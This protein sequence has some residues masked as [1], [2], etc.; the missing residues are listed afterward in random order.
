MERETLQLFLA[1]RDTGNITRAASERYITQSA[2]SKRIAQLEKE[3]GVT[4]F[5]RGKGHSTVALTPAGE[6]FSDIAERMLLLY[7][8]ALALRENAGQRGLTVACINS[9]QG[10]TL[11]GFIRELQAQH[12]DLCVTLEDHHSVEIF[13]LLENKRLDLGITQL[14][15]P[16]SDLVSYPL[17][18]EGYRVVTLPGADGT[19]AEA[20]VHPAHLPAE[21]EIFEAFDTEFQKWHDYWWRPSGCKIRVNTTPTAERYFCDPEDWMI[22]PETVAYAMEQKG[23]CSRPLLEDPPRHRVYVVH[24]KE[25][26]NEM[27]RLFASAARAYYAARPAGTLLERLR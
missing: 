25:S 19:P 1:I 4:L 16:F 17:F 11:P 27:V 6:G 13:P 26:R 15:A 14:A 2:A 5:E 7:Q 3:L 10:Y 12:P 21:H 9:V 24:H 23:F 20:P 22:V 8:Q 18:E